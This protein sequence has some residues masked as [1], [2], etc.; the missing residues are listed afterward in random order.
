MNQPYH[1]ERLQESVGLITRHPDFPGKI[2]VIEQC[3]REI[4]GL[5]RSGCITGEQGG[6]LQD[7]LARVNPRA[8]GFLLLSQPFPQGEPDPYRPS[9]LHGVNGEVGWDSR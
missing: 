6:I 3:A 1:F 7:I 4:D 8:G 9:E 2:A 5:V